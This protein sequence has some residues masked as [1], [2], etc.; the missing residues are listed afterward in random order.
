MGLGEHD[1]SEA[2]IVAGQLGEDVGEIA[3]GS[4]MRVDA[5]RID[6]NPVTAHRVSGYHGAAKS[7]LFH[8]ISAHPVST[9]PR[10][11]RSEKV[12]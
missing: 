1:E 7:G 5:D 11:S 8:Y 9:A 10:S 4:A 12:L 2:T 3:A 6:Q